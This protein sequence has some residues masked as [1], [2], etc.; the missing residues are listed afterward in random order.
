[1]KLKK[2]KKKYSQDNNYFYYTIKN[3]LTLHGIVNNNNEWIG[4]HYQNNGKG[5]WLGKIKM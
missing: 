2:H 4:Y 3:K 5:F 1:M